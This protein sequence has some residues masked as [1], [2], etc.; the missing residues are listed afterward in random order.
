MY[1]HT[2][3]LAILTPFLCTA[4]VKKSVTLFVRRDGM[5]PS[6]RT[7]GVCLG[8]IFIF[9]FLSFDFF[10]LNPCTIEQWL[11]YH[12]GTRTTV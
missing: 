2:V 11:A 5:N 8:F 7:C 4:A 10:L 9:I 12:C 3:L 1:G 6:V